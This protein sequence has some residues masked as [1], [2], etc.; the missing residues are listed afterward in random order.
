MAKSKNIAEWVDGQQGSGR[1]V[2]TREDVEADLDGS[3]VAIQTALRRL[4]QRGRIASPRR[5]FY[6]VV[7]PEYRTAAADLQESGRCN[8]NA[9]EITRLSGSHTEHDRARLTANLSPRARVRAVA[10][11]SGTATPVPK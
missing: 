7:P 10:S 1:Y 4:K 6:V 8:C 2:F 9:G 11:S 5:G 3:A